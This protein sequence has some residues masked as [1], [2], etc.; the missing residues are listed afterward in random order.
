MLLFLSVM[1]AYLRTFMISRH[2]LG[3]EA[4]ALRQQLGVY[5]RKQ[6][7]AKLNRFRSAVLGCCPPKYSES[8]VMIEVDQVLSAPVVGPSTA[9]YAAGR[10]GLLV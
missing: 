4:V 5:K 10:A 6:P 8:F 7:R 2:T 1:L 3:L 9:A